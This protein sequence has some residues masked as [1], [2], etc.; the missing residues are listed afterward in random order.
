MA[1]KPVDFISLL[2]TFT[3]VVEMA[4]CHVSMVV[5]GTGKTFLA[6]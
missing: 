1:T 4:Y 2:A 6:L 5:M 3:G